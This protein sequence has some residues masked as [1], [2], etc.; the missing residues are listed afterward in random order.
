MAAGFLFYINPPQ[1]SSILLPLPPQ[2]TPFLIEGLFA[3]YVLS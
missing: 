3:V 2:V 1:N